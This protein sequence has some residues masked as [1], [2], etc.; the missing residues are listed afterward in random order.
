MKLAVIKTLDSLAEVE[1]DADLVVVTDHPPPL[2]VVG[3]RHRTV[4]LKSGV[5]LDEVLRILKA[6]PL[7]TAVRKLAF[8]GFLSLWTRSSIYPHSLSET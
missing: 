2:S 1:E 7:E 8:R 5:D 6:D 4:V 3:V